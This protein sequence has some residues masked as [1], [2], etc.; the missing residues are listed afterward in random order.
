MS[1]DAVTNAQKQQGTFKE[2]V[3]S[4]QIKFR[5]L[6]TKGAEAPDYELII[7]KLLHSF[8][9]VRLNSEKQV[10]LLHDQ[11]VRHEAEARAASIFGNMLMQVVGNYQPQAQVSMRKPPGEAPN[12]HDVLMTICAC[13]CMDDA[14][15]A[16]CKCPCHNGEPCDIPYCVPCCELKGVTPAP[17][18]QPPGNGGQ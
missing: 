4:L 5:E 9:M 7:V 18:P 11:I 6:I 16:K 2:T 15:A 8:E 13:G 14:D 10:R 1:I 3:A 17:H 12:E